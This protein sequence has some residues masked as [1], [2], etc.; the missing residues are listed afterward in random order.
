MYK[1][2]QQYDIVK[3][4]ILYPLNKITIKN[5]YCLNETLYFYHIF[6][7]RQ[8]SFF[9]IESSNII[10]LKINYIEK[11]NKVYL[12]KN[13]YDIL[14]LRFFNNNLILN[15]KLSFKNCKDILLKRIFYDVFNKTF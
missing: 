8:D 13:K 4:N 9:I 2:N 3:N 7:N 14:N 11:S 15:D 12:K 1:Y 10:L 6:E 5:I